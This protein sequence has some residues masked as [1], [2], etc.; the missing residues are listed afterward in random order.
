MISLKKQLTIWLLGL[1][2]MVGL[3]AGGISYWLAREDA[4]ALLDHQLRLVA[5]S[6]DEGSQLPAMQTRFVGEN[7]SEQKTGFVIQVWVE[8]QPVRTSRPDFN[9]PRGPTTGYTDVKLQGEKW[10][11]YT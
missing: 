10:R 6:I 11:A 9:L 8:N 3:L 7:E 2:T 1:L 4:S 5:E